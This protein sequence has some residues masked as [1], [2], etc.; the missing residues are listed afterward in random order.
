MIQNLID[1]LR[2]NLAVLNL[3]LLVGV[4]HLDSYTQYYFARIA[5]GEYELD[6]SSRGWIA[7]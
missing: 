2:S 3:H 5:S 1:D 4:D 6:N 7:T